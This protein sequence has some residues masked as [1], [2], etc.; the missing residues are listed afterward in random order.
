MGMIISGR[1]LTQLEVLK[2]PTYS[3]DIHRIFIAFL[4]GTIPKT[5]QN[6]ALYRL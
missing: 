3:L 6:G 4:D 5:T 2:I 1:E